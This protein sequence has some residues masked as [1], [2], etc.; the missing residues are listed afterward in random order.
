[1]LVLC[2]AIPVLTCLVIAVFLLDPDADSLHLD[3][4]DALLVVGLFFVLPIVAA[5]LAW[6]E[7]RRPRRATE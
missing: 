6:R 7:M 3:A 1:M 4:S 2:L 5:G